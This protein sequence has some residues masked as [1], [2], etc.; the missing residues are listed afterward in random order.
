MDKICG[1]YKITSPS[2]KIYIGQSKDIN[3]R[4]NLYK[5]LQ[6]ERQPK[7]YNSFI[8]YGTINHKFEVLCECNK[9]LLNLFDLN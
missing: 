3:K 7:L 2:G 4:F 6:C 1:I 9:E 5:R 8:K